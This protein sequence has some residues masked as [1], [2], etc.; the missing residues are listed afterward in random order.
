MRQIAQVGVCEIFTQVD[1]PGAS[2]E[3]IATAATAR[4]IPL[5]P[6]EGATTVTSGGT[7]LGLNVKYGFQTHGY[8]NP[9]TYQ[10]KVKYEFMQGSLSTEATCNVAVSVSRSL[11]IPLPEA[12]SL[13]A[14]RKQVIDE[15]G[16]PTLID[17]DL[18]F[19]RAICIHGVDGKKI[20]AGEITAMPEKLR[21][22]GPVS[23]HL[24]TPLARV[25]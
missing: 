18:G 13:D 2:Y 19:D 16:E 20:A 7:K 3:E 6:Q 5:Y 12:P 8:D 10:D 17:K 22:S 1:T 24:S 23:E 9:Y 25:S 14:L 21:W 4:G 11:G 15:F